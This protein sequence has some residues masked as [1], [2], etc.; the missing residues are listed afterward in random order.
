MP[1]RLLWCCLCFCMGVHGHIW[2]SL[3]TS[4]WACVKV[5]GTAQ[6]DNKY[7][8]CEF[9]N[10]MSAEFSILSVDA[11]NIWTQATKNRWNWK[12][13]SRLEKSGVPLTIYEYYPY[14]T[15][16]LT[17]AAERTPITIVCGMRSSCRS[18]IYWNIGST[19]IDP[20]ED[21]WVWPKSRFGRF[22]LRQLRILGQNPSCKVLLQNILEEMYQNIIEIVKA[23]CL[24]ISVTFEICKFLE[25]SYVWGELL[26][27]WPLAQV[28]HNFEAL[29]AKIQYTKK[30]KN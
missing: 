10:V 24:S 4:T 12:V 22:L 6:Y 20:R 29:R 5:G 28:D 19:R 26:D 13:L 3:Y 14:M 11:A 16:A 8:S 9:V 27:E 30:K 7:L 15:M 2:I 18:C 17:T 23:L 21:F 1:F 25:A